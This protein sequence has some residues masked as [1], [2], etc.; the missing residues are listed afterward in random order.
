MAL[1]AMGPTAIHRRSWAFMDGLPWTGVVR[2]ERVP[3]E[4]Q[5]SLFE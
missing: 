4:P 1:T 3:A 2:Y 5:L